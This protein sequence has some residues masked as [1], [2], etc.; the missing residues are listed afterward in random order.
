MRSTTQL[1]ITLP[2]EMA[3]MVKSKVESGEY[4]SESEVIRDGLRAMQKQDRALEDWLTN[5]VAATYD[6]VKA[7]P[8]TLRTGEQVLESLAAAYRSFQKAT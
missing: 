3:E 5:E 6:A 1:S 7:D 2:N 8:S 4:A